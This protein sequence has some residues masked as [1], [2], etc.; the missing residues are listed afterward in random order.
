MSRSCIDQYY[1][2]IGASNAKDVHQLAMECYG[3]KVT[4]IELVKQLERLIIVVA[5]Q[6]RPPS[7]D[8][9]DAIHVQVSTVACHGFLSK[10]FLVHLRSSCHSF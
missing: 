8:V 5:F 2:L 9:N 10:Y 6:W 1:S 7:N 3:M 4:G